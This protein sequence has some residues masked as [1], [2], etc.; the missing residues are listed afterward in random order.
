MAWLGCPFRPPAERDTPEDTSPGGGG[1][2]VDAR[3][4]RGGNEK[5]PRVGRFFNQSRTSTSSM[6]KF[7]SLPAIS[8]LASKVMV[9]SSLAATFTGM[10]RP[11]WSCR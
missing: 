4:D 6:R 1:K 8:W 5:T 10:G 2:D 11:Y 9:V 3:D 7:S